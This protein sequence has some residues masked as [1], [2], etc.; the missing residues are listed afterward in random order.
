[1]T[2]PTLAGVIALAKKALIFGDPIQLPLVVVAPLIGGRGK[3]AGAPRNFSAGECALLPG[4]TPNRALS[5]PFGRLSQV[6]KGYWKKPEET[7]K[8]IDENGYMYDGDVGIFDE[9][10]YL[11]IVDRTKDMII[12][13]GFKVFSSK[14]EDTLI[15][16][17]AI[18]DRNYWYS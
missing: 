2:L 6:M 5:S 14:L 9:D 1:M 17:P 7:Q 16:H 8:A 4:A 10:G 15:Q 12:V 11:R 18:Y 13:G 3:P